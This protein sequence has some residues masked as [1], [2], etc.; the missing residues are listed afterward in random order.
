MA[1]AN[2]RSEKREISIE[3]QS[4]SSPIESVPS[5]VKRQN[6]EVTAKRQKRNFSAKAQRF[7]G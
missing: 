6:V 4:Q 3:N 1:K 5:D 7:R 2:S